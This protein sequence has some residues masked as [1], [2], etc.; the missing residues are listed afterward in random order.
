MHGCQGHRCMFRFEPNA[1]HSSHAKIFSEQCL[2]AGRPETYKKLRMDDLEFSRE[3]WLTG[4]DLAGS[5]L[6]VNAALSTR[7]PFEVFDDVRNV[8]LFTLDPGLREGFVEEPAGRSDK[9]MTR[10]VFL[11]AR[12]FS[13]E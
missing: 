4:S 6:F 8:C 3:P 13:D 1:P 9:R 5:W 7:L 10:K 2:G 11:I 12:L